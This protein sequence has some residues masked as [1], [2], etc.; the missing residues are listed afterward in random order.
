[1]DALFRDHRRPRLHASWVERPNVTGQA[2]TP[3]V[4]EERVRQLKDVTK[5]FR[6]FDLGLFD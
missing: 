4:P 2:R 6:V 3:A 1:M 5:G